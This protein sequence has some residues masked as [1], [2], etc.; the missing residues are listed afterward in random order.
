MVAGEKKSEKK[1]KRLTPH[2]Q[3]AMFFSCHHCIASC[4]ENIVLQV[5]CKYLSIANNKK[6]NKKNKKK[7][8]GKLPN[9]VK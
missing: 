1:F 5:F 4:K 6:K 2:L 3:L 7:L 9:F 8:Q